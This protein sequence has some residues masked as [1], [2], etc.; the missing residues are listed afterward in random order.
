MENKF[1][2]AK[3]NRIG[4]MR[5]FNEIDSE[6]YT[7]ERFLIEF[8]ALESDDSIDEI[9]ILIN[10]LGGSVYKGLPLITKISNSSK[11]VTTIIDAVGASMAALIFLAGS[12]RKM[13]SYS[14][15][16]LHSAKYSDGSTDDALVNTNQNIY[17]LVKAVTKRAKDKI[18]NWMSKD[19]WF[20]AKQALQENLATELINTKLSMVD[21]YQ[22]E[23][24]QLVAS[25]S[26]NEINNLKDKY[27][28]MEE[29]LNVL[30]LQPDASE[31]D[32][33]AKVQEMTN[34]IAIKAQ[35]LSNRDTKINE[36]QAKVDSFEAKEKAKRESEINNLLEDAVK[37]RQINAEGK[38]IW[39][40]ILDTDFDNGSKA[41]KA[42]TK[43][44]KLSDIIDTDGKTS[45]EQ[46]PFKLDPIQE[47]M[48]TK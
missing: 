22:H 34:A 36:L 27:T 28:R 25:A 47:L 18:K 46:R 26:F 16:M 3:E 17:D 19:T 38:V 8:E 10:S 44:E 33:M 35:E 14:Q 45:E 23:V 48:L 1:I 37:N 21:S 4:K 7:S 11:P 6:G 13:Y 12:K 2:V 32:V 43:T 30:S 40:S 20:T 9:E 31:K 42:L 15:L 39:K 41:I 5:L 29:I 24:R